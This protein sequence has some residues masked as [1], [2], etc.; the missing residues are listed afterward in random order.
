MNL[1]INNKTSFWAFQIL[2]LFSNV[3]LLYGQEGVYHFNPKKEYLIL[4]TGIAATVSG[5]YLLKQEHVF[6]TNE[7]EALDKKDVAS[8]NRWAAGNYSETAYTISDICVN[9]AVLAPFVLLSSKRIRSDVLK[10][11]LLY[12][13]SLL[14]T[15]GFYMT[16]AG[17]VSKPRPFLYRADVPIEEKTGHW[18]DDSF[19]SG[20]TAYSSTATFFLAK[21]LTDYYPDMRCRALI[22]AAAGILP[23]TTAYFRVVAGRHFLTDVMAGYAM[24]ALSGILVPHFHKKKNSTLSLLPYIGKISGIVLTKLF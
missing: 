13:E 9:T 8:I 18:A 2:I 22:W 3:K 16:T 12:A 11:G 14:L 6:T 1:R 15:S 19:Y 5:I 10:I 7:V 24:G 20:H 17:S 21:V 4:G 23:A